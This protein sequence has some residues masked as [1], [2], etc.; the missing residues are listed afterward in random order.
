MKII[1]GAFIFFGLFIGTLV[2]ICVRE[3]VSLVSKDYYQEELRHQDKINQQINTNSLEEKPQF[4]FVDNSI[5]LVFPYLSSVEKGELRVMRPSNDKLDQRFDVNAA[6]GDSQLFPFKVWGKGLY[7][8][9]ISWRMDG[10]DYY[11]EKVMVL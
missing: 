10:K 1:V 6:E 8:V 2:F 3:D 4:S 11:F 5:K 7:R 9:S